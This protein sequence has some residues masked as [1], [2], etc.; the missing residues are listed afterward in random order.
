MKIDDD[1]LGKIVALAKRGIGGEKSAAIRMVK[2]LCSKYGIDFDTVMR[3]E[4]SKN[5]Y[6]YYYKRDSEETVA[7]HVLFKFLNVN[8]IGHN[9]MRKVFIYE[10]T[11]EMNIEIL[12]AMPIY[13]KAYR[14]ERKRIMDETA[15]AFIIKHQL[16][17][18]VDDDKKE[19]KPFDLDRALRLRSMSNGMDDVQ[20][21]KGIEDG[22]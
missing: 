14:K 9:K 19:S 18:N 5:E 6:V 20:I 2:K 1:K 17:S 16:F 3:V 4:Q 10:C 12:N 8:S 13:M 21:H 7:A 11:P 22:K 15:H